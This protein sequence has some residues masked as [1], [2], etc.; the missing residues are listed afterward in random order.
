MYL[1]GYSTNNSNSWLFF[2]DSPGRLCVSVRDYY[3]FKFQMRPGIFNPILYGKR[4]FQQFAINTYIK[5]ESSRLDYIRNHQDDIRADLYQGL[6]DSLHAGEGRAEAVGK[7]TVMPSSFIG[8]SRVMRRR[9]MDAMALVWR[10]GKPDIFLTM[11]CNPN[12]DEIKREL[13]PS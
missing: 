13:Y 2:V 12:W 9:Y 7:R 6:V 1:S 3:C 11:T 10:F 4:L 8:G 5:I